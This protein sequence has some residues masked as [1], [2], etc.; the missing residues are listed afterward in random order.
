MGPETTA[1]PMRADGEIAWN[2]RPSSDRGE[3]TAW[4]SHILTP[5]RPLL[6]VLMTCLLAVASC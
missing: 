3:R 1:M 2:K 5:D 6:T 4:V